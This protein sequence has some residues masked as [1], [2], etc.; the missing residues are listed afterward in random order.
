MRRRKLVWAMLGLLALTLGLLSCVWIWAVLPGPSSGRV[1]TVDVPPSVANGDL[2]RFLAERGFV[3]SPRLFQLYLRLVRPSLDIV[4][5]K[6]LLSDADGPRRLLQRLGRLPNRPT[7]KVT[8]PEGFHHVL[9]AERLAKAEVCDRDAFIASVRSPSLLRELSIRGPS[10]EG[11]LFPATYEFAVDSSGDAVVRQMVKTFRKRFDRLAARFRGAVEGYAKGRSW[12]EHEIVTLASIV[13]RESRHADERSRIA[14]VYLNRLDSAEF[15]PSKR[16]QADP[17][18]AYGCVVSAA[19]I[20]SCAG[21]GGKVT[22]AMLR[23]PTNAYNTYA[24]SGLPPGPIAN[25]GEGSLAAV[26]APEKSDYLFFVARGDGRHTFSRTLDEHR[27]AT[28]GTPE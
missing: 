20:P 27:R 4:P 1:E 28:P 16:L 24:H 6:H 5:G 9:V 26:L 7:V 19:T 11:L 3:K 23:D 17:T 2:G 22:P 14:G 12:G 21:F 13:E 15:K 18:A 25:P 8:I 10:A